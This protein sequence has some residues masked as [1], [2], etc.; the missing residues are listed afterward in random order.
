MKADFRPARIRG[1]AAAVLDVVLA[2]AAMA[3]L[4]IAILTVVNDGAQD[5]LA[6]TYAQRL[7]VAQESGCPTA[8]GKAFWFSCA[9]EVRRLHP[10]GM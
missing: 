10:S 2:L 3:T 8:L 5:R 7:S 6:R 4:T 1:T 9:S